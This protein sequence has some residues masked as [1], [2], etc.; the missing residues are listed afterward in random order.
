MTPNDILTNNIASFFSAIEPVK[1]AYQNDSFSYVAVTT[2]SGEFALVQGSLFLNVYT[3]TVP[4]KSFESKGIR[5]EHFRL[6]DI[7]LTREQFIAQLCDGRFKTP[8]GDVRFLASGS[9]QY[10]VQFQPYHEVGLRN[11][12]R[13]TH[14]TLVGAELHTLI[15]RDKLDWE[16]RACDPPFDGVQDL[17]IE[18]QPGILRHSSTVEIAALAVALIDFESVVA[19]EAAHLSMRVAL[20]S[21][22]NK[23]AVGYRVLEQGRV[24]S[25][26][27]L[28][29]SAFRWEDKDGYRKGSAEF[30][31]PRAAVVHAIAVYN[32]IAQAHYY[33]GDPNCFQNPRRAAYE[34]FDPKLASFDDILSKSLGPRPDAKSFEA[35]MPW[36]FWM[37]GFSP[38][39]IGGLPRTSES[40][41]FICATPKGHLAVVECTVGLLKDDH[42]LPKLHDRVQSVRRNLDTPSMRHVHV[43]PVIITAKSE[44]EVRPELEQAEKFGIL[45]IT[46]ERIDQLV[47]RTLFPGNADQLYEEAEKTVQS[48]RERRDAQGNLQL[49][50]SEDDYLP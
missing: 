44:E 43:L 3:P 30:A 9:N 47:Q 2:P 6:T 37:L 19:G 38:A 22:V 29:G 24:V 41:D 8:K 1:D 32:D 26:G 20:A 31:V 39:H 21:D 4:F 23:V 27:R 13:L 11:Q 5:A 46:R 40:A 28:L 17:L 7:G 16:L 25:R 50:E 49:E 14:L 12:N 42:K 10:G 15:D 34:A 33:F 45:V 35:A 18:F 48:A 36:L